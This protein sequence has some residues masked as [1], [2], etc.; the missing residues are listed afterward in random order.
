MQTRVLKLSLILTTELEKKKR[1]LKR[2]EFLFLFFLK[3]AK[4]I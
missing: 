2:E 4:N 3:E 1:F